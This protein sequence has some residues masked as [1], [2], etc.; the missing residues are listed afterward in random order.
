[1]TNIFHS[2]C[3]WPVVKSRE[4]FDTH[5]IIK[6]YQIK[7]YLTW[8]DGLSWNLD[9]LA[10]IWIIFLKKISV[11]WWIIQL[12]FFLELYHFFLWEVCQRLI[13]GKRICTRNSGIGYV[14]Y[15]GEIEWRQVWKR[16]VFDFGQ[17]F[18]STLKSDF[19]FLFHHLTVLYLVVSRCTDNWNKMYYFFKMCRCHLLFR[20]VVTDIWQYISVSAFILLTF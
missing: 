4:N 19:G 2:K 18:G 12:F 8:Y 16:L 13:V 17:F 14:Q 7:F 1:M 6:T 3:K 9:R 15:H 5:S 10:I 20:C 11:I